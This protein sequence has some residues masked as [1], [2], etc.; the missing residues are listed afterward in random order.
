MSDKKPVR[1]S[2]RATRSL[3]IQALYS[4]HMTQLPAEELVGE[5]LDEQNTASVEIDYFIDLV[6]GVILNVGDVDEKFS[7]Y[8]DIPKEELT[9]VELSVLRLATYELMHHPEIPYKVVI[10]EALE[11]T[12]SFGTI[13]G[14]KFVNGVL[15]KA[16]KVLRPVEVS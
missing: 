15:D 2:R 8:L 4:W 1:K 11:L 3:A 9:P 5:F 12:K 16:V 7:P 6:K 13:E 10:N 14:Y